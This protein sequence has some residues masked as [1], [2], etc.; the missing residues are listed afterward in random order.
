MRFKQVGEE[1]SR[2]ALGS[3]TK[4]QSGF[5]VYQPSSPNYQNPWEMKNPYGESEDIKWLL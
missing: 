3:M 2:A 4:T 1:L 5:Q